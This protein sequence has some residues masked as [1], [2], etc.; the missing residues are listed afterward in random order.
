M[1]LL[2]Y[3]T[4]GALAGLSCVYPCHLSVRT[5]WQLTSSDPTS[6]SLFSF[7]PCILCLHVFLTA[8]FSDPPSQTS[9]VR[10]ANRRQPALRSAQSQVLTSPK[11]FQLVQNL[12]LI[13]ADAQVLATL[14]RRALHR[15]LLWEAGILENLRSLLACIWCYL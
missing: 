15:T 9:P 8:L 10:S 12:N 14:H 3:F 1:C 7:S 4:P 5:R 6:D 11:S 13:P 2:S